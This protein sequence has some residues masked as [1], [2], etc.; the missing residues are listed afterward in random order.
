MLKYSF[1]TAS[2]YRF[3]FLLGLFVEIGYQC[4][5]I[6][7]FNVLYGNIKEIAGWNYNEIL[8]LLGIHLDITELFMG[9]VYIQNLAV[10]PKK[11][12]DGEID[13]ALLKPF[14]SIFMLTAAS[15]IF[16][17]FVSLLP[18]IYLIFTALTHIS[19]SLNPLNI[20]MATIMF[21]CGFIIE[22]AIAT[23]ITSLAFKYLNAQKLPEISSNV[24]FSFA[25]NPQQ[26]YQGI[27]RIFFTFVIPI[28]F[29]SSV[30]ASTLIRPIDWTLISLGIILA[31]VFAYATLKIWN[32]MIRNYT[33]ASS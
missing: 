22:Y 12:K 33:S 23:I 31:I 14:S 8:L 4:T 7:F 10:L 28:V 29:V 19:G 17:S 3:N 16:I 2:T 1:I 30:P 11:I 15:P 27:V 21:I 26:S 9:T 5:I 6:L 32:I 18:G 24:I 20:V 13:F 25:K